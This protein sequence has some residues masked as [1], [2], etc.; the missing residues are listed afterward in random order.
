M[1]PAARRTN[2]VSDAKTAMRGLQTRLMR[3]REVFAHAGECL[4]LLAT[5][6]RVLETNPQVA[7]RLGRRSRPRRGDLVWKAACWQPATAAER[8]QAAVSSAAHGS[9]VH[10]ETRITTAR[11]VRMLEWSLTPVGDER[12]GVGLILVEGRDLTAEKQIQEAL[13]DSRELFGRLVAESGD[14]LIVATN[15]GRIKLFNQRAAAIFGYSPD[16]II[17][18]PLTELIPDARSLW[19]RRSSSGSHGLIVGAGFEHRHVVAKRKSGDWFPADVTLTRLRGRPHSLVLSLH[20]LS[21][22]WAGEEVRLGLLAA[23]HEPTTRDRGRA[24]HLALLTEADTLLS[25]ASDLDRMLQ[26]VGSLIIPEVAACCLI[27]LRHPGGQ[28]VRFATHHTERLPPAL[29]SALREYPKDPNRPFM[30]RTALTTGATEF[31]SRLSETRLHL[32]AQNEEL[33]EALH[34]LG[35]RSYVSVPLLARQRPLGVITAIRD[36]TMPPFTPAE[37]VLLEQL[38]Q[39]AAPALDHGIAYE[40]ALTAIRQRD[41]VMSVVTHDLRGALNALNYSS[42]AIEEVLPAQTDERLP[43]LLTTMRESVEWM[44]RLI[45]DLVDIAS[46][47]AGRLSLELRAVEPAALVLRSARQ[48]EEEASARGVH[49]VVDVQGELPAIVADPDRLLQVLANL[50]SNA[51]KFTPPFGTITLS[52]ERRDGEVVF[53]VSDSGPGIPEEEQQR[54]F[55]RFEHIRRGPDIRGTGLGLAIARGIVE[56]HG[57]RIWVQSTPGSGSRFAFT[58]PLG[59]STSRWMGHD[60]HSDMVGSLSS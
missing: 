53:A 18:E 5:D 40:R 59:A 15:G 44:D 45:N 21:E 48:F 23:A 7:Q 36:R 26:V 22:Q 31:V 16:E 25:R 47:E 43:R 11:T 46:I 52:G 49:L 29:D 9:P 35:A 28:R 6:G 33:L 51:L 42:T 34:A 1:A 54:I 41:E 27:D 4:M 50:I 13:R 24:R 3:Y 30:G 39:L 37:V 14:A 8:W 58:I 55:D 32:L 38:A 19:Q 10:L 57:G 20:D 17:G 60:R 2:T 12:G 56:S